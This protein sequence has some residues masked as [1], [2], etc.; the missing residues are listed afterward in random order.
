[1]QVSNGVDDVDVVE[2][3]LDVLVVEVENVAAFKIATWQPRTV[4]RLNCKHVA[5]VVS[6]YHK[7]ISM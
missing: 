4:M 7:R 1:M 3:V 6:I 5:S 2:V